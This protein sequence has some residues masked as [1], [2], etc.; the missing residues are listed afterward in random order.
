[1]AVM[2]WW[3]QREI[4]QRW[5]SLFALVLLIGIASGTVFTAVA[6]A[7]RGDSALPRLASRTLPATVFG[8][9]Y[10][11]DFD[12]VGRP[13]AQHGGAEVAPA[14]SA[15]ATRPALALRSE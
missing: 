10:D 2:R 6:G 3:L 11:S 9:A 5:R 13:R 4:R 8:R 14:R 12:V 15:A 1:M 7:R